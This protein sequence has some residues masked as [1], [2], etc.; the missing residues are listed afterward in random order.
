MV[1]AEIQQVASCLV[2]GFARLGIPFSTK[3][4]ISTTTPDL[5]S[6]VAVLLESLGLK[7]QEQVAVRG[8]GV[9]QAMGASSARPTHH[10]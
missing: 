7:E 1:L 4:A 3:S 9:G 6:Q 2:E 10:A 5:R 8:L